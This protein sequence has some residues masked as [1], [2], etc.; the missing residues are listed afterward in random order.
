ML[1]FTCSGAQSLGS[2]LGTNSSER[3]LLC[4]LAQVLSPMMVAAKTAEAPRNT[5]QEYEAQLEKLIE[6]RTST[7]GQSLFSGFFQ[8]PVSAL[9]TSSS[10]TEVTELTVKRASPSRTASLGCRLLPRSSPMRQKE[11]G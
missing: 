9:L 5:S 7:S 3:L 8:Q 4:N 2:S 10:T 1:L 11:Q 6:S